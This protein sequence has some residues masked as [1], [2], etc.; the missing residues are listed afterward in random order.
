MLSFRMDPC[1]RKPTTPSPVFAP[2]RPSH[3]ES[4]TA[5]NIDKSGMTL[6][7]EEIQNLIAEA[8][9]N[10]NSNPT[11]VTNEGEK[12]EEGLKRG[13]EEEEEAASSPNKKTRVELTDE[14]EQALLDLTISSD[15]SSPEDNVQNKKPA[16]GKKSN[17]LKR[18]VDKIN[19]ENKGN[20]IKNSKQKYK[21]KE[22]VQDSDS[23][24]DSS[25]K[26]QII[27]VPHMRIDGRTRCK[28]I[29]KRGPNSGKRCESLA[30]G[31]FCT[32]HSCKKTPEQNK[33]KSNEFNERKINELKR[34]VVSLEEYVEKQRKIYGEDRQRLEKVEYGMTNLKRKLRDLELV[35]QE[36]QNKLDCI[37][38]Q[39]KISSTSSEIYT[40]SRI[41][42]KKLG[43]LDKKE[44]YSLIQT[45]HD[46]ITLQHNGKSFKVKIPK[47]M[48]KPN[49][50]GNWMMVYKLELEKWDWE[51]N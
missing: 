23:E 51:R 3:V 42:T 2:A 6:L 31:D 21:S 50:P 45:G 48:K 26:R 39:N 40:S 47:S 9:V 46:T 29:P 11:E 20:E 41:E 25:T 5:T 18:L 27:E 49:L 35:N 13:L 14:H 4:E 12:H 38:N 33:I 17:I 44:K 28:F 22:F 32:T 30:K 43:K 7:E 36:L 8:D 34:K 16:D 24:T 19:I 10:K 37:L 15:E 1:M